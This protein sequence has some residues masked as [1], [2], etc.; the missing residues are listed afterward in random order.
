MNSR[1]S[2]MKF[3]FKGEIEG[4]LAFLDVS[5]NNEGNKFKTSVYREKTFTGQ[6]Q[7]LFSN[8]YQQYKSAALFTLINRAFNLTWRSYTISYKG[9]TFLTRYFQNYGFCSSLFNNIV[10]LNLLY[11]VKPSIVKVEK[12]HYV[13]K[14][15]V[16]SF[17][18][19]RN[20]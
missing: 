3:A 20:A 18:Y 16:Q 6:G 11:E 2:I 8:I 5:V 13:F 15:F 4:I 12:T 19:R 9:I 10:I 7:I 17:V 14:T 1:H